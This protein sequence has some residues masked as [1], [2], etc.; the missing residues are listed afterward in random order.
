MANNSSQAN[1]SRVRLAQSTFKPAPLDEVALTVA[2]ASEHKEDIY[3]ERRG[4][5]WRWSLAHSGG[6]YPLLRITARFLEA[7]YTKINI[8]CLT[9][10]E[11]T[12]LNSHPELTDAPDAWTIIAIDEAISTEEATDRIRAGLNPSASDK[13]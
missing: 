9:V 11:W 3:V 10:G 12:I 8:E 7:D 1:P 2:A 5:L 6:P 13:P 4:D